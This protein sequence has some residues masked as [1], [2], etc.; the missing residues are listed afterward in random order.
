MFQEVAALQLH[1]DTLDFSAESNTSHL[2][3]L[4]FGVLRLSS[5]NNCHR[6]ACSK[7]P[8]TKWGFSGDCFSELQK[9]NAI[10]AGTWFHSNRW[11]QHYS[12]SHYKGWLG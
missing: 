9:A 12:K 8:M 6:E 7:Q 4:A 5:Y 3:N 11:K 1:E 10:T 2:N